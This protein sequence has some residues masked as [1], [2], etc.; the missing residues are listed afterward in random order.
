VPA[1]RV[2]VSAGRTAIR[3]TTVATRINENRRTSGS[4]TS[5]EP[6]ALG[7]DSED[8]QAT[9]GDRL[10]AGNKIIVLRGEVQ[11]GAEFIVHGQVR[12][13]GT[14]LQK[15]VDHVDSPSG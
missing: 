1:H 4:T 5:A 2:I 13:R 15:P 8:G 9:G 12:V 6:A 11:M 3:A 7:F 10:H 14:G